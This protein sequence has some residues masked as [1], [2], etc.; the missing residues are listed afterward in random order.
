MLPT[1]TVPTAPPP[2]PLPPVLGPVV[3]PEHPSATAAAPASIQV[4]LIRMASSYVGEPPGQRAPLARAGWPAHLICYHRSRQDTC[5]H[6]CE[7]SPPIPRPDHAPAP[8]DHQAAKAVREPRAGGLSRGAPDGTRAG[9]R[10]GRAAQALPAHAAAVQ[11]PS[12]PA[13][14]GG[15]G[16]ADGRGGGPDGGEPRARRHAT[17]G[18]DG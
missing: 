10:P 1:V 5:C 2:P 11:R 17:A 18:A 6:R 8:T 3:P 14:R 9:A 4:R 13:R 16:S 15:G 7:R 12:H